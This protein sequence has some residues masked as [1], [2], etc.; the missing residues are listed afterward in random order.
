MRALVQRF[1]APDRL[2]RFVLRGLGIGLALVALVLGGRR[3][4]GSPESVLR[5]QVVSEDGAGL[6]GATVTVSRDEQAVTE[7]ATDAR[8]RFRIELAEPGHVDVRAGLAVREGADAGRTSWSAL[9]AEAL[10]VDPDSGALRLVAKPDPC[11]ATVRVRVT[12]SEGYVVSA[13]VRALPLVYPPEAARAGSAGHTNSIGRV[14]LD[15]LPRIPVALQVERRSPWCPARGPV[16]LPDPMGVDLHRLV[17]ERERIVT[18]RV[19]D[20][21]GAPVVA[22]G[23]MVTSTRDT[24]S[25]PWGDVTGSDGAFRVGVPASWDD[26]T[27]LVGCERPAETSPH[28]LATPVETSVA[29][30]ERPLMIVLDAAAAARADAVGG[31]ETGSSE[32]DASRRVMEAVLRSH[33]VGER[34]RILVLQRELRGYQAD[35]DVS[36]YLGEGIEATTLRDLAR[37]AR[38]EAVLPTGLE[39]GVPA[40]VLRG[41]WLGYLH[42]THGRDGYRHFNRRFPD[43]FGLLTL[44]AVGFSED[45]LQAVM[46]VGWML[47]PRVGEGH[48]YLLEKRD[49]AWHVVR[50]SMTWI[51]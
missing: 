21:N 50:R 40:Y 38:S 27:L 39:V 17:V 20:E 48:Y 29:A 49:G 24:V 14:N 10:D 35:D 41:A 15:G 33:Y 8:G 31:G 13:R 6:G 32:S 12:S 11:E 18:G 28:V 51:S 30:A 46:H 37:K 22:L 4:I 26:A 44:S 3:A 16:V 43:A 23:V 9:T 5:G 19:L 42:Q 25:R 1:M 47:W 36:R 2:D 45:G 7:A 34:R